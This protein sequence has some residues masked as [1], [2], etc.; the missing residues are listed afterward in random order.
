VGKQKESPEQLRANTYKMQLDLQRQINAAQQSND[1]I[2]IANR[3]RPDWEGIRD[4]KGN[5][6]EQ[7]RLNKDADVGIDQRAIDAIRQKGMSTGDSAWAQMQLQKSQMDAQNQRQNLA[8]QG[9]SSAAQAR[10]GMAMRGGVSA[11]ARE[12]I[13]RSSAR[14]QMMGQQQVGRDLNAQNL[15]IRTQDEQMKNDALKTTMGADQANAQM[16]LQNRDYRGNVDL[17]NRNAAMLDVEGKGRFDLSV[18]KDKMAA[19]G[20]SKT[21]DAQAKSSGG[22]GKK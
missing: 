8:T 14:D 19:Y 21:A 12:R 18:Y 1:P 9:A 2:N 16:G 4:H 3:E 10:N 20:A 6:R 15:N 5:L 22:G 13:A 7:F 11:G 17:Q